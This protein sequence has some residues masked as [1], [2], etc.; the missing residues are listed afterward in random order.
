M[1]RLLSKPAVWFYLWLFLALAPA[2][3]VLL[4][5]DGGA[6]LGR[7]LFKLALRWFDPGS[8]QLP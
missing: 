1:K 8:Y 2:A 6:V 4:L 3:Y 5:E 7:S